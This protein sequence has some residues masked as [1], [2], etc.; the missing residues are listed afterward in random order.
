MTIKRLSY[1]CKNYQ[2]KLLSDYFT[3]KIIL[4]REKEHCTIF[5]CVHLIWGLRLGLGLSWGVRVRVGI[6]IR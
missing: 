1:L 4:Q 6:R 3:K 5:I 2:I